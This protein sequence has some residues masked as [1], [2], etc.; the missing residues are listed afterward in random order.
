[1]NANQLVASL[2]RKVREHHGFRTPDPCFVSIYRESRCYGGPEEGGWWYSRSEFEGGIPFQTREEA[3]KWLETAMKE[4][5]AA[6]VKTSP[7]RAMAMAN[8]PDVETAYHDEGY[9]PQGW[10]DGG[11]LRVII[12]DRLGE[13]DNSNQETPHYE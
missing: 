4:V 11:K 5:E 7:A 1:M 2:A 3:E 9:I 13:F 8:L 12:E 10:N 6:N